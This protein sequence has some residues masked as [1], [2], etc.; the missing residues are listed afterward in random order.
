MSFNGFE[1]L[2]RLGIW[3][4]E[5]WKFQNTTTKFVN[6]WF[7]SHVNFPTEF[8][9]RNNVSFCRLRKNQQSTRNEQFSFHL[10]LHTFEPLRNENC[11][12]NFSCIWI[13]FFWKD[14]RVNNQ[15]RS[16]ENAS[17]RNEET[18]WTGK[19]EKQI[20]IHRRTQL[21]LLPVSLGNDWNSCSIPSDIE[22]WTLKTEQSDLFAF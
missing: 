4:D 17:D 2:S 11:S 12:K 5:L 18:K 1:E 21:N 8:L 15:I 10:H 6:C 3:N 16:I 22:C 9:I 19:Y 13:S 7:S 14:E 20:C